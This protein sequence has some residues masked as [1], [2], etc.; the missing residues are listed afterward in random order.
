MTGEDKNVNLDDGLHLSPAG[1]A[2]VA[3][4]IMYII[5]EKRPNLVGGEDSPIPLFYPHWSAIDTL[6]PLS[7]VA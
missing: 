2:Y 7:I 3:Q 4:K 1:N 6:H 5:K